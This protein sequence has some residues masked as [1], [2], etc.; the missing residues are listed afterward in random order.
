MLPHQYM[1]LIEGIRKNVP[2]IDKAIISTHTHNDLGNAVANSISGI[3]GG[4]R[5]VEGTIN[6]IGE[7]AGNADLTTVIATLDTHPELFRG[8]I[9]HP[10][11]SDHKIVNVQHSELFSLSK[12]VSGFTIPIPRNYP[13]MGANAFAHESGVHQDGVSKNISTYE[14]LDPKKYGIPE[15]E[16]TLSINS[17]KAGFISMC[18]LCEIELKDAGEADSLYGKYLGYLKGFDGKSVDK[19]EFLYWY[20]TPKE[21]NAKWKISEY[22]FTEKNSSNNT[23]TILMSD[24]LRAESDFIATSESVKGPIDANINVVNKIIGVYPDESSFRFQVDEQGSDAKAY[25]FVTIKIAGIEYQGKGIDSNTI[26]AATEAYINAI[27]RYL[28][29]I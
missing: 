16:M 21:F 25:T 10:E 2:N 27:N 1:T 6:G 15:R 19:F 3:M 26:I 13:V 17:G 9:G 12:T 20:N 5:Q 8:I 23:S 29:S 4:A 14:I 11:G 7:R 24:L 18:K 28:S 22:E